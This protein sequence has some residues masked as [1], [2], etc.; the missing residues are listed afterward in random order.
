MGSIY[1]YI[2]R[3]DD[4]AAPNPFWDLCTLAICKPAIRRKAREGSWVIGTGSKN[5]RCNDGK[6]YDFSGM[7]VYAMKITD[8]MTLHQYDIFCRENLP[9]KIPDRKNADWKMHQGDAI[10]DYSKGGEPSIREGEHTENERPRDL[11]GKNVLL[12][13]QFYYFG[14]NPILLPQQLQRLVKK[15][16]GHKIIDDSSLVLQFEE[17]ITVFKMGAHSDPQLRFRTILKMTG[18][19]LLG[20]NDGCG[21]GKTI[22]KDSCGGISSI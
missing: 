21:A 16:Q 10:Y 11:S 14:E 7:L 17:W 20:C 13:D 22:K 3:F 5:S 12:S 9:N 15:N 6:V 1:S 2:L 4:G 18:K 8:V 19:E